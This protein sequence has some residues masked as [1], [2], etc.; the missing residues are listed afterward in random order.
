MKTIASANS[1]SAASPSPRRTDPLNPRRYLW[2]LLK[3]CAAVGSIPCWAQPIE[4]IAAL[5]L[6]KEGRRKLK[7]SPNKP[8]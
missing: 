2:H 5:L 4:A 1:A 7:N 8:D 3:S 6:L